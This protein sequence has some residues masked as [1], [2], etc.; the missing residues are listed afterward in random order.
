MDNVKFGFL[1]QIVGVVVGVFC[2]FVLP[3]L[4]KLYEINLDAKTREEL[5][6]W[7]G[8]LVPLAENIFKEKGQGALKKEQVVEWLATLGFK[9]SI[10]QADLIIKLV[11]EQFNKQGWPSTN[12]ERDNFIARYAQPTI[13]VH[14]STKEKAEQFLTEAQ[15]F[16]FVWYNGTPLLTNLNWDAFGAETCYSLVR[17]N[18]NDKQSFVNEG[19]IIVE[20]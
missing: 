13:A 12:G 7:V 11:V 16:G 4:R 19:F 15:R 8:K 1:V 18:F 20:W 9:I 17:G 3:K 2:L 14:C 10:E 6:Y 5:E